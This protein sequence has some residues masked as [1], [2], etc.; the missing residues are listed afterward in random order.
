MLVRNS[1]NLAEQE[2]KRQMALKLLEIEA[3]NE[4]YLD[5][6]VSSYRNPNAPPAVPPQYKD[7]SEI[8]K[9]VLG[10]QLRLV[11]LLTTWG[12][13]NLKANAIVKNIKSNDD[14]LKIL[15]AQGNLK[16]RLES[17]NKELLSTE[18]VS[19]IIEKFLA[20]YEI[21]RAHV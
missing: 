10:N 14:V 21:G 8:A 7:A 17:Y 16:R 13:T 4:A 11:N 3:S 1:K 2:A 15:Q 19:N 9:D 6:K 20:N 5:S 12:F 18:F